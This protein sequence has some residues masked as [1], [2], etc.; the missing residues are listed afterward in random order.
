MRWGAGGRWGVQWVCGV[1]RVEL[2][3]VGREDVDELVGCAEGGEGGGAAGGREGFPDDEGAGDGGVVGLP[4]EEEGG[5]LG[6]D[7]FRGAEEV[8]GAGLEQWCVDEIAGCCA[9]GW[10]GVREGLGTECIVLIY[11]EPS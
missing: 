3:V 9:N 10:R 1:E 11:Q 7:I 8:E 2:E 4:Q 5:D 6:E